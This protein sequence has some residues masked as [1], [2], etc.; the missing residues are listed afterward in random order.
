[1]H[2]REVHGSGYLFEKNHATAKAGRTLP[3]EEVFNCCID[4]VL[5]VEGE[6]KTVVRA[7]FG[8]KIIICPKEAS[9]NCSFS[10]EIGIARA[11]FVNQQ[12]I[13]PG[14]LGCGSECGESV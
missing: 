4:K 9:H 11:L 5:G 1:M 10:L 3:S 2:S 12:F 7:I 14:M 6:D 13:S 8:E